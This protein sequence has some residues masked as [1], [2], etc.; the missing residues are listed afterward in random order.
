M[1]DARPPLLLASNCLPAASA[2]A[3]PRLDITEIARLLNGAPLSFPPES[4]GPMRKIEA[5]AA[6]DV[7]QAW[8]ACCRRGKYGGFVSFSE[9]VGLPLAL[10]FGNR[11]VAPHIMIAHNLT[12]A[13]KR[14]LHRKTGYLHNFSRIIVL[15]R[16][17][18]RY[19][20]DEAGVASRRVRFVFDKVDHAFF[21]PESVKL[22][23]AIVAVGRERRDYAT[24]AEAARRLPGR[25]FVIVA[26]SPWAVRGASGDFEAP[27][28]VVVRQGL[29]WAELRTLYAQAAG[30]VVPLAPGTS[31]AAGVNAV[32]EAMAMGKP[33]IV[34]RTPGIVD[35][36]EDG[37][38]G[39]FVPAGDAVALAE[40][41]E[42]IFA[43][44]DETRRMGD[45]ARQV[46]DSGRNLD[47]YAATVAEIVREA[48]DD[49]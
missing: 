30:V 16:A 5:R 40:A 14:D 44:P 2:G 28:N 25:T 47:R 41:V 9:K 31:Y 33:L 43:N 49:R 3:A 36:V 22:G 1:A 19:L 32:L 24:L 27:P 26:S 38:T 10:L 17:Q 20:L 11:T 8:S 46:I 34:T 48:L 29:S 45:S 15:C 37:E 7:R 42:A 23:G 4:G 6:I 39:R 12:S 18:E 35:Y 13:R 21:R